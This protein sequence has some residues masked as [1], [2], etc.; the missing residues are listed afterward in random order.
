MMASLL[1]IYVLIF[2]LQFA[3]M[4]GDHL[5]AFCASENSAL[6]PKLGM[7]PN[8]LGLAGDVLVAEVVIENEA[9]YCDAV[10]KADTERW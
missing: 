6:G 5:L 4:V 10:M 7:S 9:A 3:V 8:L 1:P 2:V